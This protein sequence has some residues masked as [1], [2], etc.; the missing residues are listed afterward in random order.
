[1]KQLSSQEQEYVSGGRITRVSGGQFGFV[2]GSRHLVTTYDRAGVRRT[3]DT[4][5]WV[6]T[7]KP[8]GSWTIQHPSGTIMEQGGQSGG[9][10]GG[11]VTPPPTPST[12]NE[13]DESESSD[14]AA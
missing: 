9:G 4:Q 11:G 12:S 7:Q 1:M 8:D 14:Q 10:A 2:D 13:V 5:G 3:M 6:A